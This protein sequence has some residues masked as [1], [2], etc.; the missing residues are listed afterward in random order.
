MYQLVEV[1][2]S[3]EEALCTHWKKAMA[4]P[5]EDVCTNL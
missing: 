2:A 1:M 5:E 3:P 4:S